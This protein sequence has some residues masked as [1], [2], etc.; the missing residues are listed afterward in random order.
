MELIILSLPVSTALYIFYVGW[1]FG[2]HEICLFVEFKY[3]FKFY[4]IPK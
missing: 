1:L 2:K 3:K 4:Y